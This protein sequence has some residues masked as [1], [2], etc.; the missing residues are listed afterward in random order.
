MTKRTLFAVAGFLGLCFSASAQQTRGLEPL[1]FDGSRLDRSNVGLPSLSLEDRNHFFLSSTFGWM[2]PTADYL[3]PFNP[4]ESPGDFYQTRPGRGNPV[5]DI[6]D[7]RA[8]DRIHFGGEVGVFYGKST[9]RYG[10]EDFESYIIGT[11]G[12][13][14]FS[15][16]AGYLYRESS[17]DIRRRRH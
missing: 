4:W 14:M 9:G 7:L 16:T 2:R 15:I 6:V 10:R 17:F 1:S 12:N 3:P 11:V 13:E 8:P 5:D